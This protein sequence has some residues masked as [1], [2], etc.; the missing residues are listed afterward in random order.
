MKSAPEG[1]MREGD[2]VSCA[3]S[4]E[5]GGGCSEIQREGE[6]KM[7]KKGSYD[8]RPT[9]PFQSRESSALNLIHIFLPPF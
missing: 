2:E 6:G 3:L 8:T 7:F 5:R 9:S 4:K 1:A